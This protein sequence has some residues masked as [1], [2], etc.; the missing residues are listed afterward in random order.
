MTGPAIPGRLGRRD[1]LPVDR[2]RDSVAAIDLD[3]MLASLSGRVGAD[4]QSAFV[5]DQTAARQQVG[6]LAAL[7]LDDPRY[8]P[9]VDWLLDITLRRP[10]SVWG[11]GDAAREY[12]DRR[13]GGNSVLWQLLIAAAEYRGETPP[14]MEGPTP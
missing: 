1:I 13:E 10:V 14:H 4:A 9:L 2:L 8:R 7:F 11:L 3:A 5:A 12:V 6:A